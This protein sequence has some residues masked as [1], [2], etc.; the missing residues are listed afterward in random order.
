MAAVHE[1]HMNL[2]KRVVSWDTIL[3]GI[4]D[5]TFTPC[6]NNDGRVTVQVDEE[7]E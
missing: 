6:I 2:C 5:A 3:K 4:R 1:N 7:I